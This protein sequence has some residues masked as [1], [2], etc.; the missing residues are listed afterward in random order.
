MGVA[1]SIKEFY[2]VK[3]IKLI[4]IITYYCELFQGFPLGRM[5]FHQPLTS[6]QKDIDVALIMK[7]FHQVEN[8][9]DEVMLA[10]VGG[11]YYLYDYWF[12][13]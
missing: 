4:V 12:H 11:V 6:Y 10:S 13:Y 8:I 5:S 9:K 3:D 1:V 2:I 7:E